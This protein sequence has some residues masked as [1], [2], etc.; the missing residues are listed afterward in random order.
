MLSEK[1]VDVTRYLMLPILLI[2]FGIMA[3]LDA[4]HC[5]CEDLPAFPSVCHVFCHD[6]DR[7]CLHI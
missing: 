1:C 6:H 5:F 7:T 2:A 3:I 4:W